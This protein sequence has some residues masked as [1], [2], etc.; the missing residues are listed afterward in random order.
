MLHPLRLPLLALLMLSLAVAARAAA[1]APWVPDLGN[2]SYKNPVLHADYSDPDAIRVGED[3]WLVS[4]SFGHAPGLPIL[5][6]RDLVNWTLVNHVFAAQAPTDHFAVPR[7]GQGVWAPALR[8]HDGKFYLYYPDPDFGIYLTTATD[9]RGLWSTPILVKA[10]RGLIDPC[11]FWDEDGQ[12]YLV[13][14]WAKSRAGI[15]NLLTLLKLTPDGTRPLDDGKVIIDANRIEGWGTLE[16]PKLY[17][18]H[19]YYYIFAPAGGVKTGWQAVFRAMDLYGPWEHRNVLDQ[20]S[21]PINGPHQGA[22][23]D[24][25]SGEDWFLH[26]Q[27]IDAYGR[28][29]HLQPM[30]WKKDWPVIGDDPGATG[31]GQPVLIHKKPRVPTQPVAVPATDDEFDATMLGHQWQWEA[32]PRAD[33]YSLTAKP[34]VLRLRVHAAPAAD[35]LWDVAQVLAQKFPA[36]EFTVTTILNFSPASVGEKAGLLIHGT[37][38]AWLGLEKTSRGF[39]LTQVVNKD[40]IKAG[41]EIQSA[42]RDVADGILVLRVTVAAGAK[43][44]FSYSLDGLKFFPFGSEFQAVPGRWVGAKVGLFAVAL[45]GADSAKSGHADFD[46]FRFTK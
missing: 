10:G 41:R 34:G 13:H 19:G 35:S 39:R 20:G 15:N 1:P 14:G 16:G 6:S 23:V 18:R 37:D 9:P 24:T 43:C 4:S 3:F 46:W 17:K 27:D 38:Y 45:P 28:V 21:T 11:P 12:L 32:N 26:F 42:V 5:H 30:V 25:P 29:V 40:A 22:W 8:H 2:G 44:S 31:R 33:F 36:P 7:H